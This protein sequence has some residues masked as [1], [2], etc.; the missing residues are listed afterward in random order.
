MCAF[1]DAGVEH[2][3]LRFADYPSPDGFLVPLFASTSAD[4]VTGLADPA[5]DDGLKAARAEPDA[6]KRQSLYREV[7]RK[8]LS[9]YVV[10]PI[11]QFESRLAVAKRV[12]SFALSPLG[13][14]DGAAVS[15]AGS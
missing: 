8:V 9:Q 12:R 15:L 10:V 7:E 5:V 13:T 1:I 3:M 4:N 14:F 6:T 2:F 11:A